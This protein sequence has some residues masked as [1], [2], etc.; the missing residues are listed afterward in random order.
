MHCVVHCVAEEATIHKGSEGL[1]Y[2][3]TIKIVKLYKNIKI[4]IIIEN[5]VFV[6]CCLHSDKRSRK[7]SVNLERKYIGR[8]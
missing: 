4:K 3:N 1:T 7:D 8:A 6:V 2:N 5:I